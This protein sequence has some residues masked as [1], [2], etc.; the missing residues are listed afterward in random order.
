MLL[1]KNLIVLRDTVQQSLIN[2]F[3]SHR[4]SRILWLTKLVT[5]D[6]FLQ[7]SPIDEE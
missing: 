5:L 6:N 3:L 1:I 2:N 7:F 4:L